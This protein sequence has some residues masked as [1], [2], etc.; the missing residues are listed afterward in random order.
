MIII[1]LTITK[2][3]K[4]K[5]LIIYYFIIMIIIITT[6]LMAIKIF[7]TYNYY[8]LYNIYNINSNK[9]TKIIFDLSLRIC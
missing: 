8:Y 7:I 2:I 5:T 6:L 1:I 3:N 9:K 4:E